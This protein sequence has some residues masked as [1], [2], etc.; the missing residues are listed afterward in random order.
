MQLDVPRLM[1]SNGEDG[2]CVGYPEQNAEVWV[3]L[4]ETMTARGIHGTIILPKFDQGHGQRAMYFGSHCSFPSYSVDD[5]Y[6]FELGQRVLVPTY[7]L[8]CIILRPGP[9]TAL[10]LFCEI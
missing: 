2:F 4:K 8:E 10:V 6:A 3:V 1:T 5:L 7:T 9:V